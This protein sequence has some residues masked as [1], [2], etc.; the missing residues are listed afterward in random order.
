M[1]IPFSPLQQ[2]LSPAQAYS[3]LPFR[4]T[5]PDENTV[6]LTNDLGSYIFLEAG[7]F[8]LLVTHKLDTI[9]KEY[10][11]LRSNYFVSD[12]RSSVH[13]RVMASRYRTKKAFLDGFTKLHIFVVTLR[14][15]HSCPYCQVSRQSEDKMKYDMPV[16]AA[17]RSVDLMLKVPAVSVTC[18]F[19]VVKR[20]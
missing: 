4:F 20:S 8:L 10:L 5:R 17:Y 9:S 7:T 15:D 19:K 2:Y 11:D 12:A 16:E 1:A 18:E 3:L 14:C 13:S 6:L